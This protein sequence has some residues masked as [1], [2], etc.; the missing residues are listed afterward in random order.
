[1]SPPGR[2][3]C[4]LR[5]WADRALDLDPDVKRVRLKC[6]DTLQARTVRARVEK[7]RQQ[8]AVGWSP[9]WS[10][11]PNRRE[12]PRGLT[13]GCVACAQILRTHHNGATSSS[14][15][16]DYRDYIQGAFD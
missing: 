16:R 12:A 8:L 2:D 7:A 3:T 14:A 1:M 5:S 9:E 11:P 10:G 13:L 4:G 15:W 6:A